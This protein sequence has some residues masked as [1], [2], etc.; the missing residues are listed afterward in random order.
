MV[1]AMLENSGVMPLMSQ[2]SC[3]RT[4]LGPQQCLGSLLEPQKHFFEEV[5][6]GC[7]MQPTVLDVRNIKLERCESVLRA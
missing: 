4:M 3:M 2:L 5:D 1:V 6:S 7:S